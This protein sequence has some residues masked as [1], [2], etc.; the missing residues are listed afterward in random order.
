V[1]GVVPTG[2][3]VSI[4]EEP[5]A[6]VFTSL[7]QMRVVPTATLF[8]RT[9]GPPQSWMQEVAARLRSV[10][11]AVPIHDLEAATVLVD[12]AL[13]GVRAGAG[14]LAAIAAIGLLLAALGVYGVISNMVGE[15][16]REVGIRLALGAGHA[17]VYHVVMGRVAVV[18]GAG[19]LAGVAVVALAGKV[20]ER[21]LYGVPA[22]DVPTLAT[23]VTC[24]FAIALLAAFIPARHATRVDPVEV[25]RGD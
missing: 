8:F 22:T 25:L 2:R 21:F 9:N 10:D 1:I 11:A 4:G 16:T 18:V 19:I 20:A 5:T 24:L 13:W 17:R 12:R 23:V 7:E 14:L 6:A 15:R 3:Q